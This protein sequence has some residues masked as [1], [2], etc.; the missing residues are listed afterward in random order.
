MNDKKFEFTPMKEE[1]EDKVYNSLICLRYNNTMYLV[2]YI[3]EHSNVNVM[4]AIQLAKII[5]DIKRY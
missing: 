5:L 1:E 2:Q 4:E 3:T